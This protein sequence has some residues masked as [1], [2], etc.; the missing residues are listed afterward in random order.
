MARTAKRR[1]IRR[2]SEQ[3][4]QLV[5]EQARSG[6]SQ[7]RFCDERGIAYASF[8]AWRRRVQAHTPGDEREPA[9]IEL[10]VGEA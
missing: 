1:Y 4:E 8:V 6:L 2:T 3:W 9:F 10:E 5:A 7:R